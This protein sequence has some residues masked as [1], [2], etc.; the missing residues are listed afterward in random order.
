MSYIQFAVPYICF[1]VD[2]YPN[3]FFFYSN[4]CY[5][6]CDHLSHSP[7]IVTDRHTLLLLLHCK[8]L[9]DREDGVQ[10]YRLKHLASSKILINDN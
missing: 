10:P 7:V 3:S 9:E 2:R 1:P 4:C 6:F 5:L 8:L